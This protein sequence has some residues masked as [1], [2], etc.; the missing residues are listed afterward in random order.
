MGMR[1]GGSKYLARN[2]S[3]KRNER[4]IAYPCTQTPTRLKHLLTSYI[5]SSFRNVINTEYYPLPS[6]PIAL[7]ALVIRTKTY[8]ANNRDRSGLRLGQQIFALF[9]YLAPILWSIGWKHFAC[10]ACFKQLGR[11]RVRSY[12]LSI[13]ASQNGAATSELRSKEKNH[14]FN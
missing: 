14:C 7:S 11:T 4:S 10:H 6:P 9:I 1:C 8:N 13:L 2:S 3:H 5:E 12:E